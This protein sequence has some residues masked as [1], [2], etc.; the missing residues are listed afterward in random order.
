[1]RSYALAHELGHSTQAGMPAD[2]T[3]GILHLRRV[4]GPGVAK[5]GQSSPA[6]PCRGCAE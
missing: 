5:V 3:E 6:T 4:R 1:M 2:R